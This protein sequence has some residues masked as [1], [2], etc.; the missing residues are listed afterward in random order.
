MEKGSWL[1]WH[2]PVLFAEGGGGRRIRR[3]RMITKTDPLM[4][5]C[6]TVLYRWDSTPERRVTPQ[7]S[8]KPTIALSAGSQHFTKWDL[9]VYQKDWLSLLE[10]LLK[11]LWKTVLVWKNWRRKEACQHKSSPWLYLKL[12]N[13][14]RSGTHTTHTHHAHSQI[15][16]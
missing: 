4:K 15:L 3:R 9:F 7:R 11:V 16:K 2:I 13:R 8:L 1:W 5:R 10:I 6:L 12:E 14:H